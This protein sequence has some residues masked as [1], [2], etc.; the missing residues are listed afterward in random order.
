MT[1]DTNRPLDL[2]AELDFCR[3]QLL[4]ASN[5]G[6]VRRFQLGGHDLAIK[7][8]KGHGLIWHA[9][10]AGLRHE[11]HAYQRIEGISGF[12]VC[13]GFFQQRWLVLGFVPG[14][15][16]RESVLTD[17]ERFFARLL[18]IIQAMHARGIAHGDLKRKENLLI[19][20][21]GDPVIIDLG[22]ATVRQSGWHPLNRW[23]F[24]FMRQTD[25]NA[26]IKLKY[27]GYEGISAHDRQYFK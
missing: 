7:A 10:R 14:S 8:P 21:S 18:Q 13:H 27:A 4:G 9:R 6:E 16:F 23:L 22:A 20:P 17:R 5:Q 26:W 3:G 25:L 2:L 19:D 24:N 15:P 1:L 11:Y 12:P